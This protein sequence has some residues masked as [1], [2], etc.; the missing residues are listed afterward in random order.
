MKR[1]FKNNSPRSSSFGVIGN[2]TVSILC[3]STLAGCHGGDG[4]PAASPLPFSSTPRGVFKSMATLDATE[5]AALVQEDYKK[6]K[7]ADGKSL[8][9][10]IDERIVQGQ[11]YSFESQSLSSRQTLYSWNTDK[12]I[13]AVTSNSISKRDTT[14]VKTQNGFSETYS[15]DYSCK[16][17][18]SNT[19]S[20]TCEY[21]KSPSQSQD[22][23]IALLYPNQSKSDEGEY[24]DLENTDSSQ[25]TTVYEKGTFTFSDGKTVA[26]LKETSKTVGQ[27]KCG[28]KKI[29][30]GESEYIAI[31]TNELPSLDSA[32]CPGSLNLFRYQII[33]T[34]GGMVKNYSRSEFTGVK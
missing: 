19:T 10:K 2:L 21:P 16:L 6:C 17:A 13:L 30:S 8:P 27:V 24:C 7:D 34:D 9:N 29:G 26:A 14:T 15:V 32:Y 11:V 1:L 20:L 31:E 28:S 33:K 23:S 4:G 18:D 3:L 12:T 25:V 5:R 22:S